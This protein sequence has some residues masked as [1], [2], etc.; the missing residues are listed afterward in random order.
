MV[1]AWTVT[2]C[3]ISKVVTAVLYSCKHESIY[4]EF[5]IGMLNSFFLTLKVRLQLPVFEFY[6]KF[7]SKMAAA[8]GRR[9]TTAAVSPTSLDHPASGPR[10][11]KRQSPTGVSPPPHRN[12]RQKQASSNRLKRPRPSPNDYIMLCGILWCGREAWGSTVGG[13][14]RPRRAHVAADTIANRLWVPSN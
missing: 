2:M 7:S 9:R 10:Q 1:N 3:Y 13:V 6:S 8:A 5:K 14:D 4:A 11:T 12:R